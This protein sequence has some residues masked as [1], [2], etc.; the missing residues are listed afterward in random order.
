MANDDLNTDQDINMTP[1]DRTDQY[2][3]QPRAHGST[4][5]LDVAGYDDQAR[6]R[7][8][9]ASPYIP[10]AGARRGSIRE[11]TTDT[12]DDGETPVM[13]RGGDLA[14]TDV[15]SQGGTR[16]NL[17]QAPTAT[18]SGDNYSPGPRQT[19]PEQELLNPDYESQ[20]DRDATGPEGAGYRVPPSVPGMPDQRGTLDQTTY[21]TQ[22]D[23]RS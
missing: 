9:G 16:D 12:D 11:D 3:A 20:I 8:Q 13:A 2:A 21:S 14:S 7:D 22:D 6:Q 10:G 1:P 4:P 15:M 23:G 18:T 19:D 5:D 17:G